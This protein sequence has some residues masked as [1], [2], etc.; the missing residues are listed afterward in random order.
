[1][2]YAR[3]VAVNQ[4]GRENADM[5]EIFSAAIFCLVLV[6]ALLGVLYVLIKLSTI[7]IRF[8]EKKMKKQER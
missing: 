7:V 4:G 1:L 8:A 5:A 3:E 2:S 6:F